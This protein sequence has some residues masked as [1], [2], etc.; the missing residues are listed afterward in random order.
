MCKRSHAYT[1]RLDITRCCHNNFKHEFGRVSQ[2]HGK[3][4]TAQMCIIWRHTPRIAYS[5]LPI[6]VRVRMDKTYF[7]GLRCFCYKHTSDVFMVHCS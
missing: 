1:L 7:T 2:A 3:P 4:N 6:V 5:S